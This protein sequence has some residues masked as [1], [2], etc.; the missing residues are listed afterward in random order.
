MTS[1]YDIIIVGSGI[2]GATLANELIR[3]G[4]KVL[5]IEKGGNHKI[6]GNHFAVLRIADKKGFRY[7][8]EHLLIA[9]GITHGGS[10]VISAGTAFWPPVDCF[11]PWGID[12]EKEL[13]QAKQEAR[14]LILPD[15][16]IGKGNIHLLEAGIRLGYDWERLPKFVDPSKCKPKCSACM[17]GCKYNAKFTAR[18]LLDNALKK[19]LEI[20]KRSIS[21]VI[22]E[23][24]KAKGVKPSRGQS[25]Y[26]DRILL[27]AGGIHSPIILQRSGINEAGKGFFMDPMIFTYG[28]A[29]KKEYRTVDEIPMA[30]GTYNFY[31]EGFFQS[32]VMEPWGLFLINYAFQRN[33]LKILKFRYYNRLMG[34]MTKIQDEKKG[35][36]SSGRLGINISKKLTER[37]L[38]R[39]KYGNSIAKEVLIEAG[40]QPRKVFSSSIRGAHPGGTCSIGE[41]VNSDLQ[42][43]IPNLFVCDASILPHS[44]GTPLVLVLMAFAKRLSRKIENDL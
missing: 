7:T 1:K 12:L 8:K 27:S 28:I 6:L 5:L 20:K 14:A 42:T 35:N 25:I 19:G 2:A 41:V 9:S 39:L 11:K 38:Q 32:P 34:I 29:P 24:G 44:L 18:N 4:K 23:N 36:L 17:L 21:H 43:K 33:P 30:V 10:S 16:L 15:K 26:A 37:D 13:K 31:K 3:I 40:S 22:I